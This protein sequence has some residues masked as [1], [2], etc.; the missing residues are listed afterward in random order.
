MS[1]SSACIHFFSYI[2][3]FIWIFFLRML[4]YFNLFLNFVAVENE[5]KT[6]CRNDIV[7]NLYNFTQFPYREFIVHIINNRCSLFS[8][9]W[10]GMD[11][12]QQIVEKPVCWIGKL[13]LSPLHVILKLSNTARRRRR[14]SCRSHM[15]THSTKQ[16]VISKMELL[17]KKNLLMTE[18]ESKRTLRFLILARVIFVS[19]W[20]GKWVSKWMSE[21]IIMHSTDWCDS[22]VISRV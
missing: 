4:T 8:W 22:N 18:T 1:F 2:L 14:R 9:I 7:I 11:E 15:Y 21:S 10:Y 3:Y 17:T 6:L 5:R 19:L 16:N 20:M 13:I 12:A